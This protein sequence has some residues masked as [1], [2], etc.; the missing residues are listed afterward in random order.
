MSV[1]MLALLISS[2]A[3][4]H[5]LVAQDLDVFTA[6]L[7]LLV[8]VP[9]CGIGLGVVRGLAQSYRQAAERAAAQEKRDEVTESSGRSSSTSAT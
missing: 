7:R 9:L 3:L 8:A 6:L 5:A 4:Y 1:L 2:P